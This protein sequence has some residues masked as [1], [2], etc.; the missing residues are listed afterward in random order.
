M[1]ALH[2]AIMVVAVRQLRA[3][4][5]DVDPRM[6]SITLQAYIDDGLARLVLP[7][8]IAMR[9]FHVWCD[10]VV[11]TWNDFGFTIERKKSFPSPAYFEFLGE[12]YFAGAHLATGSKAAMRITAEPFEVY[13][14]LRDRVTKLSTACRGACVAGLPPPS[15][16]LL[17]SYMVTL[18]LKKWIALANP[19]A[20][21]C[22]TLAPVAMGG[23]GMPSIFQQSTNASGATTEECMTTLWYWALSNSSVRQAY[24]KLVRRGMISRSPADVLAVP[25]GGQHDKRV[26]KQNPVGEYIIRALKEHYECGKLS[27]LGSLMMELDDP[28]GDTTFQEA[29][30]TLHPGCVYQEALLVDLADPMPTRI[31]RSFIS[32]FE[33]ARTIGAFI[34][35]KTMREVVR[36]NY[37]EAR[38]AFSAFVRSSEMTPGTD[39][40]TRVGSVFRRSVNTGAL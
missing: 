4:L 13:E 36:K 19:T 6:L 31:F 2:I 3:R 15:A 39:D 28:T 16:Y 7:R 37:S 17:Q 30:V 25:L 35:G 29:V 21:A 8:G 14:S 26:M 40:V 11:E 20:T 34:R 12:E 23:L 18:E 33:S 38:I 27:S 10:V 5:P 1:T 22:W 32:R 24:I 9:I